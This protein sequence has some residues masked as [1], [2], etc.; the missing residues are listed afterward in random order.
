M[1]S[2]F[3]KLAARATL[4]NAPTAHASA[5][6]NSRDPFEA[7]AIQPIASPTAPLAQTNHLQS[8]LTPV[9]PDA[10]SQDRPQ[11]RITTEMP[12]ESRPALPTPPTTELQPSNSRDQRDAETVKNLEP[13]RSE[14]R[15]ETESKPATTSKV[16]RTDRESEPERTT[17][18]V[19]NVRATET[20]ATKPREKDEADRLAQMQREQS[21]LLRKA[22]AFMANVIGRNKLTNTAQEENEEKTQNA[23]SISAEKLREPA[24]TRLLP[25]TPAPPV[26]EPEDSEPSIVIGNLSVEVVPPAAPPAPPQT[27]VIVVGGGQRTRSGISSPQR[28]GFSRF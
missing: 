19:P 8:P 12:V 2:Y 23:E 17:I 3:E 15:L 28:F 24:Q 1:K 14:D 21:I 9:L 18:V 10:K 5:T 25:P 4:T 22:D 13:R 16:A 11:N 20:P 26:S 27:K 7:D 6:L